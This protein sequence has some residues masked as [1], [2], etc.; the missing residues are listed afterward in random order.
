MKGKEINKIDAHIHLLP[1]D[2]LDALKQ[3]EGHPYQKASVD[4]YLKLMDEFN[5]EKV[6]VY[7]AS[8]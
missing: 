2:T 1:S 4:K 7:G 8:I 6:L 3:Y 5:I